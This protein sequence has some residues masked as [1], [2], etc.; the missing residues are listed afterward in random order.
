MRIAIEKMNS[1]V[2]VPKFR[3]ALNTPT[4]DLV[5]ST[6]ETMVDPVDKSFVELK[7]TVVEN[8]KK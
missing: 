2:L 4:T 6:L 3:S 1:G 8:Q 5:E 7:E